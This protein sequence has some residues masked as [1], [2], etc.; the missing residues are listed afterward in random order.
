MLMGGTT[1][2]STSGAAAFSSS[3]GPAQPDLLPTPSK[4]Q[5]WSAGDGTVCKVVTAW[6]RSRKNAGVVVRW[7]RG[8]EDRRALWGYVEFLTQFTQVQPDLLER[9]IGL[10]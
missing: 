10:H 8:V 1:N 9:H 3:N 7:Q 6:R 2:I 4:G 5:V